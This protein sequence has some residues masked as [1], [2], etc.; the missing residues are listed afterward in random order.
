[1]KA[2]EKIGVRDGISRNYIC[3]LETMEPDL[4][5][6]RIL[7]EETDSSELP[8]QTLSF[9]GTSQGRQDGTDYPEGRGAGSL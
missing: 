2:G 9:S 6:A 3:E 5:R 4:V 8:G 7:S 1:M